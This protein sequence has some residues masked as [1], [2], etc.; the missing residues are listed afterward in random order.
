[1]RIDYMAMG[2]MGGEECSSTAGCPWRRNLSTGP[3]LAVVRVEAHLPPSANDP[4][5]GPGRGLITSPVFGG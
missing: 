5:T 2:G 3:Q 4:T 1:M